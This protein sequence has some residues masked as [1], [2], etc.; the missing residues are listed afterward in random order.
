MYTIY[1]SKCTASR[2][3]GARRTLSAPV[4]IAPLA[5]RRAKFCATR[6]GSLMVVAVGAAAAAT[7]PYVQLVGSVGTLAIPPATCTRAGPA[8]SFFANIDLGSTGAYRYSPAAVTPYFFDDEGEFNLVYNQDVTLLVSPFVAAP[9]VQ[10]NQPFPVASLSTWYTGIDRVPEHTELALRVAAYDARGVSVA[11]SRMTWDCTTGEVLSLE[12]RGNAAGVA[13]APAAA[14]LVEFH[15]AGLDHYFV[16]ADPAEIALLDAGTTAGW[17]RTGQGFNV[18]LTAASGAS[19]V[20]RFYLPPPYGDSHF[21]SASPAECAEVRARFPGF[22]YES[23]SVFF[24]G[25][26]A[27]ATGACPPGA[28][29][30]YRLWN[31]RSDSNHRYTADPLV[32]AQMLAKGYVAEGYGPDAVIMCAPP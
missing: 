17:T 27:S 6:A 4:K 12:H 26:P 9:V 19:P 29:P 25:L 20:C 30:I 18:W 21:Y 28:V 3:F 31:Q 16:S 5:R 1:E 10:S 32:K 13:P 11:T 15:H 24:A 22:A 8:P 14:R 7:P 23:P 2:S